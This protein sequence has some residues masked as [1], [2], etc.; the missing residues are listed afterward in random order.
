VD[1]QTA[2]TLRRMVLECLQWIIAGGLAANIDCTAERTGKNAIRYHVTIIRPDG[3]DV[4]ITEVWS[5]V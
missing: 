2:G 3:N 4:L 1:A 5:A